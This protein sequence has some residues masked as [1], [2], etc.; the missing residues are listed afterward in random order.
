MVVTRDN[1]TLITG[2]KD[3]KIK[4]W[5]WIKFTLVETLVA[6]NDTVQSIVLS[7]DERLLFSGSFDSN[8][9]VWSMINYT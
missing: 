7:Q 3:K 6:H 8:V 4:I 1:K 2:S 5:D 9:F